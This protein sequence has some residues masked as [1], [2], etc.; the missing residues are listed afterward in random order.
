[1]P[2]GVFVIKLKL[3]LLAAGLSL[4]AVVQAQIT[5]GVAVSASGVASVIGQFQ[6]NTV[7][8]M[9]RSIAGQT[10]RYIVLDDQSDIDQA[11]EN[12]RRFVSDERVDIVLGP[13]TTPNAFAMM[14]LAAASDTPMI[15]WAGARSIVE[16]MD[17]RRRH[18]F[19][20]SQNDQQMA[21]AV[22][23]HMVDMGVRRVAFIGFA[24]A[25]GD[26][27]SNQLGAIAQ[28]RRIS[29]VSLQR[30]PRQETDLSL[31]IQ[32][33]LSQ[34]P[35]AVFIA[36]AGL[37]AALPQRALR[38]YGFAGL[39]YQT[40]AVAN[41]DFLR[42]CRADCEGVLLAAGPVLVASQLGD[43]HPVKASAMAYI[44]AYEALHGPDSASPFGAHAW[45]AY[46]LLEA[47]LPAALAAAKPGTPAF[48]AALREALENVRD[49]AGAHG[50]FNM[51]PTDHLGLDQRAVVMVELKNGQWSLRP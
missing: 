38:E 31:Q 10:V 17:E 36:A 33:L 5:V 3:L 26:G 22:V 14:E 13:T 9:P 45:D 16:P 27:W 42:N 39:I 4:A 48:R 41:E 1:M 43:D 51:S 7:E 11:R 20:T 18:V 32:A 40:P 34:A 25:Y 12:M 49:V 29:V 28:A 15:A 2:F 8:L 19:K 30:Y 50:V 37:A 35:D 44:A 24:D 6:L 21:M 46:R 23:S 47:A